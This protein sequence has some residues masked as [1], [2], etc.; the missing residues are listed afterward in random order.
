MRS[1]INL[2]INAS[3]QKSDTTTWSLN[4]YKSQRLLFQCDKSI[5]TDFHIMDKTFLIVRVF[6]YSFTS[7]LT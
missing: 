2:L 1:Q 7:T 3:M 5:V 6:S 4:N